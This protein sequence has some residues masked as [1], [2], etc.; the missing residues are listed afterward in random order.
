M[1]NSIKDLIKDSKDNIKWHEERLVEYR[2]KLEAY[3]IAKKVIENQQKIK[4]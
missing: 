4:K 2:L 1:M 3:E